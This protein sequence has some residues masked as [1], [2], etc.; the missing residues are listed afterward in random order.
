MG[1][2]KGGFLAINFARVETLATDRRRSNAS[3]AALVTAQTG[4]QVTADDVAGFRKVGG[5][6]SRKM[7][8]SAKTMRATKDD[9][10]SAGAGAG[11]PA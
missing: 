9:G 6:A 3:I 5:I 1:I 11:V 4:Q 8:V 10:S 2:I 7:L